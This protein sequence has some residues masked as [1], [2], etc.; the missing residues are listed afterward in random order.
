MCAMVG[1]VGAGTFAFLLLFS[2]LILFLL[3]YRIKIFKW[4]FW[5]YLLC[6]IILVIV[7]ASVPIKQEV[8]EEIETN[9][10]VKKQIAFGIFIF[11]GF[12]L[13]LVFYLLVVLLHQDF[14]LVIPCT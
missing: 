14:A 13:S 1:D 4:I 7:M 11:L 9:G 3:L 10:H 8:Q 2:F 5:I 12:I 6:M